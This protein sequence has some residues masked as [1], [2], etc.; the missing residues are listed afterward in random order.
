MPRLTSLMAGGAVWKGVAEAL[1]VVTGLVATGAT[2]QAN[3]LEVGAD[4]NVFGTVAAT[5]GARL[6]PMERG[7]G[8]VVANHGANAL[9]L[10]PPVGGTL[11][12]LA[13]N[14]SVSV[15][16]NKPAIVIALGGNAYSVNISA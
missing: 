2:S 14:A 16:V 3:S 8:I 5:T 10:Y 13:A 6:Q 15:P 11:N 1:N 12:G 9:L 7:E 4:V